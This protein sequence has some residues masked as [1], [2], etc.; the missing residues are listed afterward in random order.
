MQLCNVVPKVK[1][2]YFH[3]LKLCQGS[4]HLARGPLIAWNY[5]LFG[6]DA[7]DFK[8]RFLDLKSRNLGKKSRNLAENQ[9]KSEKITEF[10]KKIT[11]FHCFSAKIGL[12]WPFLADFKAFPAHFRVI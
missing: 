3:F 2:S 12:F 5:V 8:S 11:F 1:H 10:S 6:H 9:R 7:A 4:N